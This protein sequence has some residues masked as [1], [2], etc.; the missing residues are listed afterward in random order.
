MSVIASVNIGVIKGASENRRLK[1]CKDRSRNQHKTKQ[2]PEF[3]LCSQS[4]TCFWRQRNIG[5]PGH[6]LTGPVVEVLVHVGYMRTLEFDFRGG[7][8]YCCFRGNDDCQLNP[9]DAMEGFRP[10]LSHPS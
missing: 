6:T 5:V 4:Y 2:S 9:P 10:H 1:S 7:R 3:H 8:W